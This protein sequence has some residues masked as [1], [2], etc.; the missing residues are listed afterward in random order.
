MTMPMNVTTEDLRCRPISLQSGDALII[1]NVQRDYLPGGAMAVPRGDAVVEPL[2]SVIDRFVRAD[3]PI[4]YVRD[5]H[6]A[7]RFASDRQPHAAPAHCVDGTTGAQFAP[8]LWIAE[9]DPI[10]PMTA[11]HDCEPVS[12]FQDTSLAEC[13]RRTE[14][15]RIFIGGLA[16]EH[17]VMKTALDAL[18]Q[19]YDVH[20][21]TD[22][23]RAVDA[24]PGDGLRASRLMRRRGAC[25]TETANIAAL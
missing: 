4:F 17:C 25:M 9:S 21:L 24:R 19:G 8:H 11:T 18:A 3:L 16:T 7:D 23:V 5:S 10:I 22:A 2:N 6:P 14:T 1:V 12:A 13:L 15:K 20:V